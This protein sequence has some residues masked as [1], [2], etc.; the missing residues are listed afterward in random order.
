MREHETHKVHI[1]VGLELF[2]LGNPWK[3]YW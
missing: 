3:D 2:F 1:L